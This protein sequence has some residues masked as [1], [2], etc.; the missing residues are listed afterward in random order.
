MRFAMLILASLGLPMPAIAATGPDLFLRVLYAHYAD[1][2]PGRPVF[3]PLGDAAT[4]WFSP[5][6]LALIRR[7][8]A[9]ATTQPGKLD[10]D[11]LCDCQEYHDFILQSVR[12]TAQQAATA[13][14]TV[15]FTN[16]GQETLLR[17]RLIKSQTGWRI[18]DVSDADMPSLRLALAS[19]E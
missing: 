19:P 10:G 9:A 5:A 3:D 12:V 18:D 15:R 2:G 14:A 17:L 6:L 8:E 7:D 4:S 1:D 13:R 16:E 11:P